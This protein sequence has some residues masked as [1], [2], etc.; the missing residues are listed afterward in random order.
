MQ[1]IFG[2]DTSKY[3]LLYSDDRQD[4]AAKIKDL[5]RLPYS[6][7]PDFNSLGFIP[8]GSNSNRSLFFH[9]QKDT[10]M[11]RNVYILHGVYGEQNAESFFGND[12]ASGLFID[13]IDQ[14]GFDR[15]RDDLLAGKKDHTIPYSVNRSLADTPCDQ[16]ELDPIVLAEILTKLYQ[17]SSILIV[18]D[19]DQYNDDRVR[20]LLK[21]IFHY[22]TPSLRKM[23]SF[24]TAV[25]NTGDMDFMLRIIPRSR[26]KEKRG[27]IDLNAPASQP[28]TDKSNFPQMI[29]VLMQMSDADR[30]IL[31]ENFELLY[32]GRDSIYKK[33]N[34][35]HF[36]A[37]AFA[38]ELDEKCL[39]TFDDMLGNYLNDAK[40]PDEPVIPQFV[41]N[42]L[43]AKYSSEAMLDELVDWASMRL[44]QTDRFYD[45]H[46]DTIKKVYYLCDRELTYFA[47]RYAASY[48]KVYKS[49]DIAE[50]KAIRDGFANV[51]NRMRNAKNAEA[52]LLMIATAS[53]RYIAEICEAYDALI[54]KGK[55]LAN[56]YIDSHYNGTR[57]NGVREIMAYIAAPIEEQIRALGQRVSDIV[58]HFS[59]R[60]EQECVDTHNDEC[61][62]RESLER[63]RQ[64]Q[65]KRDQTL[66]DFKALLANEEKKAALSDKTESD[67]KSAKKAK[68]SDK[69]AAQK[70]VEEEDAVVTEITEPVYGGA[71]DFFN[72]LFAAESDESAQQQTSA[73]V[74]LWDISHEALMEVAG[75]ETLLPA[76]ADA[77]TA[78]IVNVCIKRETSDF[79]GANAYLSKSASSTVAETVASR[80]TISYP[81]YAILYLAAYHP[82]TDHA[83]RSILAMKAVDQLTAKQ[84][85]V[86][87]KAL[88]EVL[89]LR[90]SN[91]AIDSSVQKGLYDSTKEMATSKQS[92]KP[93]K[94]LCSILLDSP[95]LAVNGASGLNKKIVCILAGVLGG[96]LVVVALLIWVVISVLGGNADD[97]GDKTAEQTTTAQADVATTTPEAATTTPNDG[98]GDTPTTTTPQTSETTAPESSETTSP[99]E[100]SLN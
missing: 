87:N 55:T 86:L 62:R 45:V 57:I 27:Y 82:Q 64:A 93:R 33:Q 29:D 72:D 71:D 18:M 58:A 81:E 15:L 25:D 17:R 14:E 65:T 20:L 6:P 4:N 11:V 24:I 97:N 26:L 7:N 66:A 51:S 76:L 59:K 75:D 94:S 46:I 3:T 67:G 100:A 68:K 73:A 99:D 23:C 34:F 78:Y 53:C 83:I 98:A 56:E 9:L 36:F 28:Y 90:A 84:L 38:S 92:S 69:K 60:I 40:C 91:N 89:S 19:D 32:Y 5:V 50:L 77:I 22:L 41:R 74:T 48:E 80:L 8:F 31:F 61:A 30:G 12:Y 44:D 1:F 39:R 96:L 21:K 16:I 37:C 54:L 88:P 43:Q 63:D 70:T 85:A 10:K 49:E 95:L 47:E 79:K 52:R 13:F 42:A 2:D 35:E